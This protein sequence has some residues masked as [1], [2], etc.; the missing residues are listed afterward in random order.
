VFGHRYAEIYGKYNMKMEVN[1]PQKLLFL[2]INDL[3]M[4]QLDRV[5]WTFEDLQK[6]SSKIK[7]L[8]LVLAD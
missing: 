7:S 8:M 5:Y 6:A 2:N 3:D 1:Y 4:Q